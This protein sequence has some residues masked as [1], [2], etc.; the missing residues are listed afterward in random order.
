MNIQSQVA[1]RRVST[2]R[3][4]IE[5][6]KL[7]GRCLVAR[8]APLTI[9]CTSHRWTRGVREELLV[10]HTK[11]GISC[12]LL[13]P[14][15][16]EL[17]S[18]TSHHFRDKKLEGLIISVSSRYYLPSMEVCDDLVLEFPRGLSLT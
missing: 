6:S 13:T 3:L 11:G 12:P 18:G 8:L 7:D 9:M 14:T 5:V 1:L 16:L 15:G 4:K 10:S 17:A 2:S